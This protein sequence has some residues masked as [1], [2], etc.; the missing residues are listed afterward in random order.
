MFQLK[1]GESSFQSGL[2]V[3]S[4]SNGTV[5]TFRR[6]IDGETCE[7][8]TQRSLKKSKNNNRLCK[9]WRQAA[10]WVRGFVGRHKQE[11]WRFCDIKKMLECG[12]FTFILLE[13]WISSRTTNTKKLRSI[14]RWFVPYSSKGSTTQPRPTEIGSSTSK[15]W[16]SWRWRI[17]MRRWKAVQ[18]GFK[19]KMGKNRVE[20]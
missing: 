13:H 3:W 5:Q 14:L 2:H 1:N 15:K 7:L 16:P 10:M 19:K 18:L 9:I 6:K 11:P 12:S 4:I 8:A 20:I 17:G